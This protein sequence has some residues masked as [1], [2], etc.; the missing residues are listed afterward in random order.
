[1]LAISTSKNY[2]KYSPEPS[3]IIKLLA[4]IEQKNPFTR[5]AEITHE[6]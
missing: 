5:S 4:E 1:M 2:F 6:T 3:L